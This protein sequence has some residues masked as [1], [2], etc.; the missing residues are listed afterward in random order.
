MC[1]DNRRVTMKWWDQYSKKLRYFSSAKFD[2]HNNKFGK[3]WS[4]GSALINGKNIS[5]LTT[6]KDY[7]PDHLFIKYYIFEATLSFP[8]M[9]NPIGNV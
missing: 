9:G 2:K 6:L 3:G 4:S 7:L 1:Y 5:A 8:P